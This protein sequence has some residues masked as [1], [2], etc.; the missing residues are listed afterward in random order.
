V[1]YIK[2]VAVQELRNEHEKLLGFVDA[3]DAKLMQII[4]VAIAVVTAF[5]AVNVVRG[6]PLG[7]WIALEVT[8]VAFASAITYVMVHFAPYQFRFPIASDWDELDEHYFGL[9]EDEARDALIGQYIMILDEVRP[10]LN[11]KARAVRV[12]LVAVSIAI[13]TLIAMQLVLAA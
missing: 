8:A 7:Y 11:T 9:S 4:Q 2:D 12:G 3:L 10:V 1:S 6:A 5:A 13:V